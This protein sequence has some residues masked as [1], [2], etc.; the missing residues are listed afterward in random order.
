LLGECMAV[1]G[2]IVDWSLSCAWEERMVFA[3]KVANGM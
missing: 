2:R 1:S 3:T